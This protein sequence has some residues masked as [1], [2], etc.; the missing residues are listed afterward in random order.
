[1]TN[2]E[3]SYTPRRLYPRLAL[4]A[5]GLFIVG[6]NAYDI[7]G[8]LPSI[9][10][11]LGVGSADVGYS[12]TYYSIVVAIAAPL[13]STFIPRWS[14]TGL[15]AAGLGLIAAGTVVSAGAHGI[16]AFTAGRVIAALGGAALVPTAT[17]A[18]AA[19]APAA[20]RGSAIAAVALGFAAATALGSPIGTAIGSSTNWRVPLYGVAA[21]ALLIGIAVVVFLGDLPAGHP[22]ALKRRFGV[23]R[24]HRLLAGLAAT[25]GVVA[26]FNGVYFFSSEVAAGATG[27]SGSRLAVLLLAYGVAGIAGSLIAG[28][29]TDRMGNRLN[30]NIF[31]AIQAAVLL[32]LPLAAGN[33]LAT[34][35]LFAAWGIPAMAS[36]VPV[37]HRLATID[38]A[39]SGIALSW[40]TTVMYV[41]IALAPLL[42]GAALAAGSPQLVPVFGAAAIALALAAF[43]LSYVAKRRGSTLLEEEAEGEQ[44]VAA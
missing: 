5:A 2:I 32:A 22:I 8:L 44:P 31:L 15:M 35:V 29:L 37:Q 43:Q 1:M 19:I 40:Y 24:D 28:R 16:G 3:P 42:G 38:P 39:T 25:L 27:G 34:A 6:T 30:A 20:K 17:A 7:A 33:Y 11:T 4:L 26:G 18:A 41:G 12:I 36:L 13:V 23:L 14:R 9:A 10:G 21:L